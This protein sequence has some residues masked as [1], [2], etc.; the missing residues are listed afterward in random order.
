M[1]KLFKLPNE[2]KLKLGAQTSSKQNGIIDPKKIEEAEAYIQKLC[3]GSN[4]EIAKN[5][6]ELTAIWD[7]MKTMPESLERELS[8][9][10]I[11]TIAHEIKDIGG[12]CGLGLIAYFGES[13]RDYIE[14][15]ALSLK[16][17]HIIIQA[18]IDA[19]NTAHKNGLRDN[20]GPAAE[21]LKRIVKIA[22]EKYH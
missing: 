5:L 21:E 18:H 13:L 6:Q 20:G 8:A 9:K 12:L 3:E 14:Q 19:M 22:I 1:I 10:K 11:F 7:I 15:T 2:L 17:Q 4:A 16:N